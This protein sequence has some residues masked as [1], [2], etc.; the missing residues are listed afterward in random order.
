MTPLVS[1]QTTEVIVDRKDRLNKLLDEASKLVESDWKTDDDAETD[2]VTSSSTSG[3]QRTSITFAVSIKVHEIMTL[4]DY[5]EK[6]LRKCWYS[7]D[8]KDKMN[9]TKD[10]TVARIEK[11][12]SPKGSMTYRGLECWT[13][14]GGQ[15]LDEQIARAIDAVMDEQDRQWKIE[16]DDWDRIAVLCHAATADSAVR[17]RKLALQDEIDAKE[18]WDKEDDL[19][20]SLH[21]VQSTMSEQPKAKDKKLYRR[22]RSSTKAFKKRA[23]WTK[24]KSQ[25]PETSES[26]SQGDL[27]KKL[28]QDSPEDTPST[29]SLSDESEMVKRRGKKGKKKKKSRRSRLD[30][31]APVQRTKSQECS[32]LMMAMRLA[33]RQGKPLNV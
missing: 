25:E 26:S 15:E 5:T 24:T 21:S 16:Q 8:D 13:V 7:I 30:P 31:P 6:E 19:T 11:G 9:A 32:D 10:K 22:R 23:L 28:A 2:S 1:K 4:D 20:E 17:A 29:G 18:A 12:K 3:P 33:C 27:P 14:K